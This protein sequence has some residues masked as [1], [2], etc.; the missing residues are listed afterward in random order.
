MEQNK[1]TRSWVKKTLRILGLLVVN[2]LIVFALFLFHVRFTEPLIRDSKAINGIE[3]LF[4]GPL[5]FV[6]LLLFGMYK[7]FRA[8]GVSL[9]TFVIVLLL[10]LFFT[11]NKYFA[12]EGE[13]KARKLR[14]N[15]LRTEK[16]LFLNIQH[17]MWY[18]A[19]QVPFEKWLN[20]DT[21]FVRIDQG[22]FGIETATDNV[23]IIES[24]YCD[25]DDLDSSDL[26]R[27]HF[28]IGEKLFYRRCFSDAIKHFTACIERDFLS[29]TCYYERGVNYMAINDYDL[30]LKDFVVAAGI[31]YKQ[32][33]FSEREFLDTVNVN[34]Y[35]ASLVRKVKDKNYKEV[36]N[37]M[38]NYSHLAS[39]YNYQRHIDFCI[40]K[41][42]NK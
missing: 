16:G 30:A 18:N 21:V 9:T 25:C 28:D 36:V 22:L 20:V 35:T 41:L 11:S 23:K 7:W 15:S 17:N 37:S 29:E 10:F 2:G 5:I 6:G 39:F 1:E 34:T 12:A 3:I 27:S 24:T 19:T 33:Q 4:F 13:Y 31:R 14:N 40:D 42:K 38:S 32:L 26:I 8:F